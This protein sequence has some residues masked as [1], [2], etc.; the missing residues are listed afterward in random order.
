M[1]AVANNDTEVI[2]SFFK[3]KI[4]NV[5]LISSNAG[6][7]DVV[8]QVHHDLWR[9]NKQILTYSRILYWSTRQMSNKHAWVFKNRA[10]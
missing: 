5:L 3:A 1:V 4:L 6:N 8:N 10:Q 2:T 7:V 9:L